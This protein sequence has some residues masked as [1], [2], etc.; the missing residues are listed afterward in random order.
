MAQGRG[1]SQAVC[2]PLPTAA[3][4]VRSQV[5][6]CMIR[7][8]QSGT[9]MGFLRALRFPLP[10]LIQPTPPY[11]FLSYH[12]LYKISILIASFNNQLKEKVAKEV[13][14]MIYIC[15]SA[16]F[17]SRPGHRLSRHLLF[18]S[19]PS[20]KFRNGTLNRAMVASFHILPNSLF[21]IIN[22]SMVC[23]LS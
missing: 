4:R 21:T 9:G 6:S 3:A 20:G 11:L 13:M 19:V 18:S 23:N 22:H 17:E 5:I 1:I 7:G 15:E 14:L 12:R 10:I 8:G 2:H 16:K